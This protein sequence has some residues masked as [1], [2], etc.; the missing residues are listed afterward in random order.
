MPEVW[1]YRPS[2]VMRTPWAKLA[3]VGLGSSFLQAVNKSPKRNIYK[4]DV[5][6]I[7]FIE[8]MISFV[9]RGQAGH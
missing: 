1:L 6:L 7:D 5:C 2:L 4:S 9:E 8:K 3:V